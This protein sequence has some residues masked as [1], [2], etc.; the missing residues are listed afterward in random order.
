MK[1]STRARYGTRA[2]LDLARHGGEKP[3]QLKDI[4][5]RQNI[6]LHYLEHIIAPLVGAGIIR[7]T[8]GVRG[9]LRL[10]RQPKD[11]KLIEVIQLLEGTTTPVDC[12]SNPETCD[13]A[14]LCVTR[15]VWCVMK[16][17]IDTALESVTLQDLVEK[18]KRKET[19][20][21]QSV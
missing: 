15:D 21:K 14:D 5:G 1:L 19:S 12:I 13:R 2:L 16:K 7:S 18:Q 10:T 6:S 4:A 8:R 11:V 17:A 20:V 3:V 9:G